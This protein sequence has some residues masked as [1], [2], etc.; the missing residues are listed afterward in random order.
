MIIAITGI[1]ISATPTPLVEVQ[2]TVVVVA[3]NLA[4]EVIAIKNHMVAYIPTIIVSD[5]KCCQPQRLNDEGYMGYDATND[6]YKPLNLDCPIR[7]S[8]AT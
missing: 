7:G 8:P 5:A 1:L 3:E 4:K 6:K 2:D